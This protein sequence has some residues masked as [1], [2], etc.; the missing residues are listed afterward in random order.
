MVLGA[1]K[2]GMFCLLR[3]MVKCPFRINGIICLNGILINK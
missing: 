1:E 2:S 3:H